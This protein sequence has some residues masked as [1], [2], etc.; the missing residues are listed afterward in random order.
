MCVVWNKYHRF[1]FIPPRAPSTVDQ[2]SGAPRYTD[3][4]PIGALGPSIS[5]SYLLDILVKKKADSDASVLSA[6]VQ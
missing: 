4:N 6:A 1:N 3:V 2:S 5:R